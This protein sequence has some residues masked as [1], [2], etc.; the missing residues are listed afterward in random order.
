M[1]LCKHC[2]KYPV[3]SHGYCKYHQWIW[4]K[5]LRNANKPRRDTIFPK[6]Y[7]STTKKLS[8]HKRDVLAS[9]KKHKKHLQI[10]NQNRCFFCGDKAHDLV[11]IFPV[12][13]FV[14]YD[15]KQWNHILGCRTCHTTFDD[16]NPFTLNNIEFIIDMI[17][18]VN[19]K[20]YYRLLNRK[21]YE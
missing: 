1:K 6:R 21:T 7:T 10:I 17:Q 13:L 20:Y 2:K 18:A 11:H 19:I 5:T 4:K 12:S 3:F 9:N 15:D 14:E 16:G 8:S